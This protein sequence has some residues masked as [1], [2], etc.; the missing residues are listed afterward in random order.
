MIKSDARVGIENTLSSRAVLWLLLLATAFDGITQGILLLQ[1]TIAKKALAATDLQVALIGVI[2]GTTLVFSFFF[3]YFY[4]G[5]NKRWLILCG[6]LAG[7]L[8]FLFSFMICR[9]AI[10]LIFLFFYHSL[11]AIQ[12]PVI[13]GFF[14]RHFGA[15]RGMV[16]GLVRSVL[17]LFMMGTSLAV[18]HLLDHDPS[19][20]RSVLAIVSVTA[21]FSYAIFFWIE[22]R[23]S[24]TAQ[25][26]VG[27]AHFRHSWAA[28]F[29]RKDFLTFEGL[30]MTYGLA[31]MICVPTVPLFLLKELKLSYFEMAQA[32]GIYA[33]VCM[34][35]TIP[36]AGRIFDR[37]GLWKVAFLS[38]GVLVF[39]PGFFFLSHLALSKPLAYTG[40]IFYS[41]GLSGVNILWNLGCFV[42]AGKEDSLVFQGFHLTLT[43]IRGFF[44]PLLGYFLLTR[45]G[46]Q[47]VFG[48]A[49]VLF[50]LASLGSLFYGKRSP[51]R[52]NR[53][54]SC[55]RET[56][57]D[58]GVG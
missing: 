22:S 42:F 30:M 55:G 7:R 2:A 53:S 20:F 15:R 37:I 25:S 13:N 52:W 47:S 46:V 11:F 1:E 44:G 36:F 43:G 48:L 31:Y 29:R 49:V 41:L 38:F 26:G 6:Y 3:S 57:D 23:A 33:Q 58:P 4:S 27:Q 14:E 18:G 19:I 28:I 34:M 50:S 32:Q 56:L 8:I 5:R 12:V 24:Y 35:L 45:F 9:S 10:F 21:L 54:G 17:M 16:F 39:Y 51:Q 40:L